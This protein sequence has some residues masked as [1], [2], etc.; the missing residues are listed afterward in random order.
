MK[1]EKIVLE[2]MII[3]SKGR[4]AI[5]VDVIKCYVLG[6]WGSASLLDTKKGI[7][8]KWCGSCDVVWGC[9]SVIHSIMNGL[10]KGERLFLAWIRN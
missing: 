6:V 10:L 3:I 4:L 8:E 5:S 1:L 2:T 9:L 7:V